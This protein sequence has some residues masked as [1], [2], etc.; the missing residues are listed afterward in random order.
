M[1][2][3]KCFIICV[4]LLALNS[5]ENLILGQQK[6]SKIKNTQ[7]VCECMSVLNDYLLQEYDSEIYKKTGVVS[8]G[9]RN[10]IVVA[11]GPS[12][13]KIDVY[14]VF[15]KVYEQLKIKEI[16]YSKLMYIMVAKFGKSYK[17]DVFAFI[18][19]ENF[20]KNIAS[21]EAIK[22]N[23]KMLKGTYNSEEHP[24]IKRILINTKTTQDVDKKWAPKREK[25]Y[26]SNLKFCKKKAL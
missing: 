24:Y 19:G 9:A 23:S 26:E 22:V 5:Q 17:E 10:C 1:K 3:I 16:D 21:F 4:A 14:K 20:K 2:E 6:F 25:R 8:L 18:T 13:Y 11:F 15:E 7:E 12:D